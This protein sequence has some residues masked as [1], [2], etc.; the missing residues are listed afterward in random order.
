MIVLLLGLIF[1]KV[2]LQVRVIGFGSWGRYEWVQ[3]FYRRYRTV[4]TLGR[5]VEL[6]SKV[7]AAERIVWL[8]YLFMFIRS[9]MT[10]LWCAIGA[11][12]NA[13]QSVMW[14][15]LVEFVYKYLLIFFK[16]TYFL[17]DLF[18]LSIWLILPFALY[19]LYFNL[20]LEVFADPLL[21]LNYQM[22]DLLLQRI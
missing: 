12:S 19:S 6:Q 13:F 4:I 5:C 22:L 14:F 7:T 20:Q 11:K 8:G 2:E 16:L 18:Q 1:S 10:R 3:G 15:E 21:L 17:F 9:S